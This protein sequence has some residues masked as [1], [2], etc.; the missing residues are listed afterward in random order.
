METKK[1]NESFQPALKF[2]GVLGTVGG[3]V[4]DVLSPLGPILNYLL[5]LSIILLII[6]LV[7]MILLPAE[8]KGLFRTSSLS[9]LFFAII[10]GAFGQLNQNTENGFMG[11]NIE[12]IADFQSSLNLIDQKLDVI[13]EQIEGVDTKVVEIDSKLEDGFE[14][15]KKD[16]KELSTE[17]SEKLD[18]ISYQQEEVL[19][20]IDKLN[21][22]GEDLRETLGIKR[23]T[24]SINQKNRIESQLKSQDYKRIY[25]FFNRRFL[26][27]NFWNSS[28]EENRQNKELALLKIPNTDIGYYIKATNAFQERDYYLA[29][30]LLDSALAINPK[31]YFGYHLRGQIPDNESKLEDLNRSYSLQ[32][33]SFVI[34]YTRGFYYLDNQDYENA[35]PDIY[36]ALKQ[37]NFEAIDIAGNLIPCYWNLQEWSS[38]VDLIQKVDYQRLNEYLNENLGREEF[39][40]SY[41]IL[42]LLNTNNVADITFIKSDVYSE[43]DNIY[44]GYFLNN[45]E[46]YIP[47]FTKNNG[48]SITLNQKDIFGFGAAGLKQPIRDKSYIE[49]EPVVFYIERNSKNNQ[50]ISEIRGSEINEVFTIVFKVMEPRENDK[51]DGEVLFLKKGIANIS[52]EEDFPEFKK[53][54]VKESGLITNW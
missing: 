5:Y 16:V 7:F 36:Q 52:N 34:S 12:L 26:D 10:F 14:D 42:P 11:D 43:V 19:T 18:L 23:I 20:S 27:F 28:V 46:Q 25:N 1:L 15:L 22:I 39:L 54:K 33:N 35:I 13:S 37:T 24:F 53:L 29:E 41:N 45:P 51:I 8:K 6:S 49:V 30:K 50:L 17:N 32:P 48:K 44:V 2:A 3:F 4:G 40:S 47:Y 31:S 21:D 38:I 9:T